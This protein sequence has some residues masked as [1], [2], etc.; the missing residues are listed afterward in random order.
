M[1]EKIAKYSALLFSGIFNPFLIPTLG[2]LVIMGFIPGVEFFSFKLKLIILGVIFLSTCFIPLIFITLGTL[3]RGWNN[4]SNHY[5]DRVMPYLFTAMSAFLGSQFFG[6]LPI[7]GIF[8]V[9]LLGICLIMIISIL[10]SLKWKISEHTLALGG[11]WGT[12]LALN[13]KFGMNILW[14]IIGVI[15]VSGVVG[16]SRIYLEKNSSHQVYRGFLT[17]MIC[18]FLIIVFI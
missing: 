8:R 9:F 1:K 15:L 5:F 12:L 6:R 18:M 2:L 3:Y 10:I 7:P 4:E 16:S 13:Y 14:M 17:G 11:L